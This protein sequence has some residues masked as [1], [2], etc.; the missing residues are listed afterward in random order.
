MKLIVFGSRN[1]FD[2]DPDFLGMEALEG[3]L[4]SLKKRVYNSFEEANA[5]LEEVIKLRDAVLAF[6]KESLMKIVPATFA[7]TQQFVS[8]AKNDLKKL[9]S[10]ARSFVTKAL[11]GLYAN[12]KT[13]ISNATDMHFH[14]RYT[15]ASQALEKAHAGLIALDVAPYNLSDAVKTFLNESRVQIDTLEKKIAESMMGRVVDD[16]IREAKTHGTNAKDMH[17]HNRYQNALDAV[18]KARDL[19][20][21]LSSPPFNSLPDVVSF[22]PAFIAQIDDVEKKCGDSLYSRLADDKIREAKTHGTN[23]KDMHFHNQY[24]KALDAVAKARD[25]IAELSSPPF[26]SVP[27]V[28][29]FLPSF[30]AQIDDVEK[31]CGDSMYGRLAD[32]KIREAKTHGT[33]AKD[34]HF[35]NQYQN[36]LDAV[37]KARDLIAELSSPPFNSIPEV[38][39]FLPSFIAQIDD[40]EKKCGDSMYGRLADEKIREAKT[41]GTNAKDMH[42]HNQYQKA[43]DAV[44]KARDMI[45]ELSSPPFNSLPDVVSFLP[46]FIAQIDDIEKKCGESM[47]SNLVDDK[48]REAKTHGTNA[49][50][51]HFHN[52]YQNALDAVAKARESIAQLKEAPFCNLEATQEFLPAFEKQIDEIETKCGEVMF[53]RLADDKIR[54]IKALGTKAKDMHFHNRYNDSLEAIGKARDQ[55]SELTQA[56]YVNLDIVKT[57]LNE[58]T[59]QID[60]IEAK[61]GEDM[62]SRLADDKVREAKT[63]GTKAKDMLFHNCYQDAIDAVAKAR[64]VIS[65]LQ[66]APWSSLAVVASF[67]PE[68]AKQI[69]EYERQCGEALFSKVVDEK[70]HEA[71]TLGTKAK[72]M[73]FHNQYQNALDA[74]AKARDIIAELKEAPYGNLKTT[75][76]FLPEFIKQIDEYERLC[77]E[78]LFSKVVDEKIHEAKTHGTNAKDMHFHNQYQN[79]LD[80]VAKARD[81]INELKEAPFA[82][83]KATQEFLPEFEKQI[84]QYERQCGEAMFGRVAED[85]IRAAKTLV[86]DA[87]NKHF[88]S[89]HQEALDTVAKARDA[90]SELEQ[91]PYATLEVTLAF[92]KTAKPALDA[93]EGKIG[94]SLFGRFV[95]DKIR[96]AQTLMT[97][98]KDLHFHSRNGEALTAIAKTR[99]AIAEL[100]TTPYNNIPAAVAFLKETNPD[101]DSLEAKVGEAM[102]GRVVFD[103]INAGKT[104]VNNAKSLAE[105]SC[106]QQALDALT[107]AYESLDEL[108][109]PPYN[110]LPLVKTYVT[111]ARAALSTL[112]GTITAAMGSKAAA[113]TESSA[114][115]PAVKSSGNYFT[116]INIAFGSDSNSTF[117]FPNAPGFPSGPIQSTVGPWVIHMNSPLSSVQAQSSTPAQTRSFLIKWNTNILKINGE[118]KKAVNELMRMAKAAEVVSTANNAGY[119][120]PREYIYGKWAV[121]LSLV[122][123]MEAQANELPADELKTTMLEQLKTARTQLK[124]NDKRNKLVSE[125]VSVVEKASHLHYRLVCEVEQPLRDNILGFVDEV[126]S[127]WHS[128]NMKFP[129]IPPFQEKMDKL[130]NGQM[131]AGKVTSILETIKAMAT[132]VDGKV[133]IHKQERIINGLK[134]LEKWPVAHRAAIFRLQK[135]WNNY[136]RFFQENWKPEFEPEWPT[137]SSPA[138]LWQPSEEDVGLPGYEMIRPGTPAQSGLPFANRPDSTKDSIFAEYTLP[139]A[140][141][142]VFANET[143]QPQIKNKDAF[144]T[145]FNLTDPIFARAVWPRS[146]ANYAIGKKKDGS[147]VYPADGLM[148]DPRAPNLIM[149]LVLKINGKPVSKK[150]AFQDCFGHFGGNANMYNTQQTVGFGILGLP[151]APESFYTGWDL[152]PRVLYGQLLRAGAGTHKV[153]MSLHYNLFDT[154]PTHQNLKDGPTNI[155]T[156]TSHPLAEGSFEVVVPAGAKMPDSFGPINVEPAPL[157]ALQTY[158]R[159]HREHMVWAK[160]E[161]DWQIREE[162]QELLEYDRFSKVMVKTKI[163]AKYGKAYGCLTYK[164]PENKW[165]QEAITYYVVIVIAGPKKTWSEGVEGISVFRQGAQFEADFLPDS[166]LSTIP[167]RCEPK[168]RNV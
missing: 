18:A 81:L 145:K 86:T 144:K 120:K 116:L 84:D 25:M 10:D 54:E 17:F 78:S 92:L 62:F 24:Q 15:E 26:N 149:S 102:F 123:E 107:K 69:D 55:M 168:F 83:L 132:N 99:E 75:Q 56:P 151:M 118:W 41:H 85:K 53:S 93:L 129:K 80:A 137:P 37:A 46:G 141:K 36:A 140:G 114:G 167:N 11:D 65:E 96:D 2:T 64:D 9:E 101:L 22:L 33:N 61:C 124:E 51:M 27:E 67:L 19:I 138:D 87:E 68:F 72:D 156:L 76:V 5:Q 3:L 48:I 79:A 159:N 154:D 77:G 63:H 94:A 38:I 161:D 16:K 58:F 1:G 127:E 12:V 153:E 122:K 152:M 104:H 90:I 158:F 126:A 20:A 59:K 135:V 29:A 43:L 60:Y 155:D 121:A 28:I 44:A 30:I 110:T 125:F 21:E 91:P 113:G 166:L 7:K 47:Y 52:Q 117:I 57:F 111:E 70:I 82:S 4:S 142:I 73:H 35:H 164:S 109:N 157:Q 150:Y 32:D 165:P 49:K 147:P 115:T 100:D 14:H 74:I 98:A 148:E 130:I 40:V 6:E 163:P 95:E 108:E 39:A 106:H 23:A 31:K 13:P 136:F 139:F 162:A 8:S 88:H 119:Y 133:P 146:I 89:I 45:A 71:K 42:F 112:E 50:D 160:L 128:L 103:K 105:H 66:Q 97:T 34:M 134:Q 143:I 131:H